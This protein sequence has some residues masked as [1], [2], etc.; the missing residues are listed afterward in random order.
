MK[1]YTIYYT[2]LLANEGNDGYSTAIHCNYI[3]SFDVDDTT[4][5]EPK[6]F[7][8][9]DFK[10]L[11]PTNT[12]GIGFVANKIYLL[13]QTVENV[14]NNNDVYE[15]IDP[16]SNLWKK[17]DVTNQIEG[18]GGSGDGGNILPNDLV[19]IIFKVKL[20]ITGESYK[21]DYLNYPTKSDPSVDTVVLDDKNLCFGEEEIFLG[22]V[23]TDINATVHTTDLSIEL[24]LNEF[25]STTNETWDGE[26]DDI[27][28]SEVGLYDENK[29]LIAMGKFNSP[30]LKNNSTSRTIVFGLDF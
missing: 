29:D 5:N 27:Y 24:K 11:S 6:I 3:N 15:K 26:N 21:L 19:N 4:G 1:K 23:N 7:F 12:D 17:Y 2:Y 30:I 16:E 25:N 28:I 9:D 22:N 10:F 8:D 14:L 20:N 13:I 18:G